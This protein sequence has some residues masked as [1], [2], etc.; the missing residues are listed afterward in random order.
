MDFIHGFALVNFNAGISA[1][2]KGGEWQQALRLF[3]GMGQAKVEP[4]V[5]SY[6]AAV[7]A[8]KHGEMAMVSNLLS[9]MLRMGPAPNIISC[10]AAISAY[11]SGG[12]LKVSK[13]IFFTWS[14]SIT[15]Q[16]P[17]T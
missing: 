8:Y 15:Q 7:S 3:S 11:N 12:S 1:C 4:D 17:D 9:S 6:N 10:C 16:S 2:E 13:N 14:R 5:I